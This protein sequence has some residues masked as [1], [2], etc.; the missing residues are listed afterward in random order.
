MLMKT[1]PQR[2]GRV[3]LPVIFAV[4]LAAC[5]GMPYQFASL[6]AAT[7]LA[8][9]P[10]IQLGQPKPAQ[11]D[12]I[13]YLPANQ[14]VTTVA[15][16]QGNLFAQTDSKTLSVQL[17]RD[18]YLYKNWI[19]YDKR[20]WLKIADAV[21]ADFRIQLPDYDHPQAGEVLIGLD[22]KS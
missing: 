9:L 11:G 4:S 3:A 12:Y 6:P 7:E 1:S 10:V 14:P 15:K 17:K 20:E 21:K 18:V 16:V 8:T 5:S 22:A 2:W 13:V 19:S